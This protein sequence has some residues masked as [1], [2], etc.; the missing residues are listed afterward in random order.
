MSRRDREVRVSDE[1]D[2]DLFETLVNS[3]QHFGDVQAEK[4]IGR[5]QSAFK[6]LA[7]SPRIGRSRDELSSGL[8]SFPAGAHVIYY[9]FDDDV[10]EIVRVLDGRRD[11]EMV[12]WSASF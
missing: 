2:L 9:V 4:Y 1:A 7:A 11:P 10:L 8:F 5:L 12:N 6:T 3:E